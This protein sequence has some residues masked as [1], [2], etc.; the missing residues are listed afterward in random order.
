MYNYNYRVEVKSEKTV[1]LHQECEAWGWSLE[2]VSRSIQT[3]WQQKQ[4]QLATSVNDLLEE[5]QIRWENSFRINE[6][7]C[8]C[9]WVRECVCVGVC[10]RE[11]ER[12]REKFWGV[13]EF[14]FIY[15]CEG[16]LV[17]SKLKSSKMIWSKVC[18]HGIAILFHACR[19]NLFLVLL[20][21]RCTPLGPFWRSSTLR[22]RHW[23]SPLCVLQLALSILLSSSIAEIQTHTRS[24][25]SAQFISHGS[26]VSP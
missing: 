23:H 25:L 21:Y 8:E 3:M 20:S 13:A 19:D 12:E 14:F 16:R 4:Q 17:W 5:D 11:W 15:F 18:L 2:L 6:W 7:V 10:E 1:L 26:L 22:N 24:A 9:V